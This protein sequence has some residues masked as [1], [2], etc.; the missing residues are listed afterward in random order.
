MWTLDIVEVRQN[1]VEGNK[2]D[3]YIFLLTAVQHSDRYLTPRVSK[4]L[5]SPGG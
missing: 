4:E 2:D 1:H 3:S 5:K